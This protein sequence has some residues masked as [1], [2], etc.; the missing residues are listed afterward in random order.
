MS[1]HSFFGQVGRGVAPSAKFLAFWAFWMRVIVRLLVGSVVFA[2]RAVVVCAVG[3]GG[4]PLAPT[5]EAELASAFTDY[6]VALLL[7]IL[8]GLQSAVWTGVDLDPR[9]LQL[10]ER[11]FF[12]FL[13]LLLIEISFAIGTLVLRFIIN[14][15]DQ[16]ALRTT[17]CIWLKS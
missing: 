3:H 1:V 10:F 14:L 5:E 9:C 16:T 17:N 7:C 6:M 8:A 4:L 13:G 15:K 11:I 2:T 12:L